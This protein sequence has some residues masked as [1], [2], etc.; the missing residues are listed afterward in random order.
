MSKVLSQQTYNSLP[1][2]VSPIDVRKRKRI[3]LSSGHSEASAGARG[4]APDYPQEE[5]ACRI[6]MMEVARILQA[7]GGFE[8]SCDPDDTDDLSV[9]G[10]RAKGFDAFIE[11]HL[12]AYNADLVD[13]Y[14]AVCVHRKWSKQ[15]TRE[16]AAVV[17]H[18]MGEAIDHRLIQRDGQLGG[19]YPLSLGVLTGAHSVGC[20]LAILTEAF[21]IDAYG[22]WE[23][24]QRRS[25]LAAKGIAAGVIDYFS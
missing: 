17:A 24:V 19:V 14:G 8:V 20:D 4:L 13:E 11:F 16:F 2:A 15:V 21:F 18:H 23:Q 12:N 25:L 10:K 22:S 9:I 5:D 3:R 1:D 7:H 6:Q